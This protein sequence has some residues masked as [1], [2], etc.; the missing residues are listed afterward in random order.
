M[1]CLSPYLPDGFLHDI[2]ALKVISA[3]YV[4]LHKILT[5]NPVTAVY[6][7]PALLRLLLSVVTP[8]YDIEQTP[9]K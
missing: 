4:K 7:S 9:V 8:V 6:Y 2:R 1:A 5:T 3:L